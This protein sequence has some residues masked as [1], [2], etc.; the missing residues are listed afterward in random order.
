MID[1][2]RPFNFAAPEFV[3]DKYRWYEKI[4]EERPVHRGKISLLTVYTV[5]R[6][7]DC[8]NLLS[9]PRVLRNRTS[10]TGGSRFPFPMPRSVRA[11]AQ[12]MIQE[13]DP[14]HRRLRGLVRKAFRP[15]AIKALETTIDSYSQELLNEIPMGQSFDLQSQ[16]ALPIPV[17]MI[18]EM[19]GVTRE[20]MPK[21]QETFG[22][23]TRSFTGWRTLRTLFLDLPGTVRFVARLGSTEKA[24]A[25]RGHSNWAYSGRGRR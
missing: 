7:E 19:M 13:D 20:A 16:Y 8:C 23:V 2:D 24:A 6:Y 3:N 11:I 21:F 15:Q 5:A 4:R 14:E 25:W 18:S 22:V 9:D 12:S 17:R 10:A 1:L